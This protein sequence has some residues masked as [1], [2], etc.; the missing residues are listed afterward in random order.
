MRLVLAMHADIAGQLLGSD[1]LERLMAVASVQPGLVVSDFSSP[2]ARPELHEADVLLTHWGC[3]RLDVDA[4]AL[5]PRLRA[6][7]HAAGSVKNLVTDACWERGLRFS[8]AA[9]ANAL[10]VAEYTIAMILLAN[11]QVLR[12]R[13]HYRASPGQWPDWHTLYPGA[14]NYRRRIGIVGASMVGR[15]VIELAQPYDWDLVLHDPFVTDLEAR[16]LGVTLVGLDQLCA[17]VDVLSLHAP[18]LPSTRHMLD[19]RRLALLHEG[20]TVVNTSRG[21]LIDQAALTAELV[22]GRLQAVIDVTDPEILPASSPLYDLP[23][24]LLT[25]HVAGSMGNEMGRLF[26]SALAELERYAAGREFAHPVLQSQLSNTALPP[27]HSGPPCRPGA[28]PRARPA[29]RALARPFPQ[30]Q[31]ARYITL[32]GA[33]IV[34]GINLYI[35]VGCTNGA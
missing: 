17:T 12:F 5:M 15:R 27:P 13:E 10:P 2:A 14:G 30:P 20:A 31:P 22:S 18:D 32:F 23:N 6:V 7:V 8:S 25:P 24:V 11:K 21:T 16:Q 19:R 1:G 34:L 4:L 3:P 29:C 9:W 26:N 33:A 35:R 28:L